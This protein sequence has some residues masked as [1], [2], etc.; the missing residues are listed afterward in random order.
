M[1]AAVSRALRSLQT[2]SL[3]ARRQWASEVVSAGSKFPV[4]ISGAGD[5]EL[6]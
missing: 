6:K 4:F 2:K 5:N 1:V 3:G